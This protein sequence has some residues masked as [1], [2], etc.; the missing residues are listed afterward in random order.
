M[1]RIKKTLLFSG[2]AVLFQASP[3]L[4]AEPAPVERFSQGDVLPPAAAEAGQAQ[5][6]SELQHRT[7]LQNAQSAQAI[8]I[9]EASDG[10]YR[11]IV[12]DAQVQIVP[13]QPNLGAE[14]TV[15]LQ[16]P[17]MA[18]TEIKE[19]QVETI[20]F[21]SFERAPIETPSHSIA[22]ISLR[23]GNKLYLFLKPAWTVSS[24]VRVQ[25]ARGV[26]TPDGKKLIYS[27][28]TY[29]TQSIVVRDLT[30]P[31]VVMAGVQA[32][33]SGFPPGTRKLSPIARSLVS[34][35][36]LV[37]SNLSAPFGGSGPHNELTVVDFS[38]EYAQI[39][40]VQIAVPQGI[41]PMDYS[42]AS[43]SIN[44]ETAKIRLYNGNVYEVGLKA[45]PLKAALIAVEPP[46]TSPITQQG[47]IEKIQADLLAGVELEQVKGLE[48]GRPE[49]VAAVAIEK[50]DA[51]SNQKHHL[52]LYSTDGKAL[53]QAGIISNPSKPFQDFRIDD[54]GR[55]A[56][57]REKGAFFVYARAGDGA[58]FR[59]ERYGSFIRDGLTISDPEGPEIVLRAYDPEFGG[60]GG[61]ETVLS[62]N[63]EGRLESQERVFVPADVL[64]A[65]PRAVSN[66]GFVIER[67]TREAGY[68][69]KDSNIFT[70]AGRYVATFTEY[71]QSA[72]PCD[73]GTQ[74]L[75]VWSIGLPDVSP[76][77]RYAVAASKARR[78]VNGPNGTVTWTRTIR[79]V[80]AL[81][82]S[83]ERT[84]SLKSPLSDE[85]TDVRFV[86][87]SSTRIWVSYA[88]GKAEFYDVR[89]G[90]VSSGIEG[91]LAP[92]AQHLGP[93]RE[94]ALISWKPVDFKKAVRAGFS[95][96]WLGAGGFLQLSAPEQQEVLASAQ[97][98]GLPA[99]GF[100]GGDPEWVNPARPDQAEFVRTEYLR[101]ME[102]LAEFTR[103]NPG[104]LRFSFGSD[105]EPYTKSWWDGD[106]TLYS[107]LVENVIEPVVREF[108]RAHPDRIAPDALTRFEP[109]W[110][111]NGHVTEDGKTI[112]GL[113]DFASSN[114]ASMTYRNTADPILSVSES[115]QARVREVS[116]MEFFLGAETKPAGPGIPAHITFDGQ[117]PAMAG[118]L[119]KA[120]QGIP[121]QQAKSLR[122]V[123]IH[124]GKAQADQLLDA[125]LSTLQA[126]PP[127]LAPV[128]P[129]PPKPV[130]VA[131]PAPKPAPAVTASPK[132]ASAPVK[133]AV[134]AV[135]LPTGIG[136]ALW[137]G[138]N[139]VATI[140]LGWRGIRVTGA[141]V[142]FLSVRQVKVITATGRA[143]IVNI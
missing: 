121:S 42:F 88:S 12:R 57:I 103:Q 27:E 123:F 15:N 136:F 14:V 142:V 18:E 69:M 96:V 35:R 84:I 95:T 102:V 7:V 108:A 70:Q 134:K 64:A 6:Q 67:K 138:G 74:V 2:F 20:R 59:F 68:S 21:I 41:N 112:R 87:G 100:I 114:V 131:A 125:L 120:I 101:L 37:V 53:L 73:G 60:P 49:M 28:L 40:Q 25:V 5:E 93:A 66:P 111:E 82:G 34:N 9:P 62:V 117:L 110:W 116:G 16:D 127:K 122:G 105:V 109:F 39:K 52:F 94:M 44:G 58:T 31:W 80:N 126:E 33:Q 30:K 85:V 51:F 63:P 78:E 106:L 43:G 132:P 107:D 38:G 104:N 32:G 75:V 71:S 11:L 1:T 86:H 17:R 81:T 89:T 23:D 19:V 119:I 113:R 130:P 29:S 83:E 97:Q 8:P 47:L 10:S 91:M 55:I 54:T 76:D 118:E 140:S 143:Y 139:R 48:T 26:I 133:P 79:V 90:E 92:L 99:L 3:F 61:R 128:V 129:A 50:T 24:P 98:A 22:E 13:T 4:G 77:G 46:Q 72:S 36:T 115:V 124:S 65:L 137:A 141:K 45:N 56:I 135:P